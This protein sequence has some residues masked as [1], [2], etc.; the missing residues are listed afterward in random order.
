MSSPNSGR[1]RT[2]SVEFSMFVD[3]TTAVNSQRAAGSDPPLVLPDAQGAR[4]EEFLWERD[5]G[6]RSGVRSPKPLCKR[7][8]Y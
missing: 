8:R 2:N 3:Q 1:R 5:A 6:G 7:G 4:A